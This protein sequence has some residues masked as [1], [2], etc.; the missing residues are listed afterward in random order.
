MSTES[1]RT[2][3]GDNMEHSDGSIKVWFGNLVEVKLEKNFLFKRWHAVAISPHLL[4]FSTFSS[5]PQSSPTP[6]TSWTSTSSS[7]W[8]PQTATSRTV[9]NPQTVCDADALTRAAFTH[10]LLLSLIPKQE[11]AASRCELHSSATRS[12]R[13]H[14]LIMERRRARWRAASSYAHL[15]A[16]PLRSYTVGLEISSEGLIIKLFLLQFLQH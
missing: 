12:F 1:V 5:S 3:D 10:T 2:S 8:S 9:M 16:S 7:V 11:R 14:W 6:S 15:R 4:S 13:S